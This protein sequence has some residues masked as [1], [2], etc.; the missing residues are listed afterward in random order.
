MFQ[1]LFFQILVGIVGLW[2][3]QRFVPGVVFT[4]TWQTL[5][6][7]GTI[8][9]LINFFIKPILKIITLPLR[10][11]TFGLF[12]LVLNMG[13][14]WVVADILFPA[15]IEILG[16]LPL[17]WTTMIIWLISFIFNLSKNHL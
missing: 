7:A 13:I 14:I 5:A 9:G 3:A 1:N 10:I 8:L 11:L 2:L 4:G 6:L 12:S 15:Q 17:F 16:L